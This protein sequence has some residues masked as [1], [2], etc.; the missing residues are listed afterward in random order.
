MLQRGGESQPRSRVK[1]RLRPYAAWR[2]APLTRRRGDTLK[3]GCERGI[4]ALTT[5]KQALFSAIFT[6][7]YAAANNW[8]SSLDPVVAAKIA[9]AKLRMEQG[10]LSNI[11]WFRG[12]G[13]YKID[14]GPGYRI[15]I[16]KDGLRI[17][18][19]L[20]G[21]TKKG[22]QK[23]IDRAVKLWEEYKVR[24]VKETKRRK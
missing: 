9:V 2:S 16:A 11:D 20:G 10:N 1:G 12:I 6:R 5:C 23:D 18:V 14:F 24:K 19:L 7:I 13:E 8:F 15:Y 21:G 22:Q 17:I 3:H 4:S